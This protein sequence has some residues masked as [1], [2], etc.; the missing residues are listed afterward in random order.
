MRLKNCGVKEFIS[1]VEGKRLI[2]FGAG[3]LILDMAFEVKT[4]PGLEQAIDCFVD[5]DSE[6]WGNC[7]QLGVRDFTI[8]SPDLLLEQGAGELV[9]LITCMAYQSVIEQLQKIPQL[10]ACD[11]YLY[12][13]VLGIPNLDVAHFFGEEIYRKP[14]ADY[15]ERLQGLQLKDKYKKRRCFIIGNGPSLTPEDLTLLRDEI[16]FASNR[17]FFIFSQTPWRPTYYFCI[18]Y[19]ICAMDTEKMQ[20]VACEN[21]FMP[22]ACALATGRVYDDWMYFNRQIIHYTKTADGKVT[23]DLSFDFSKDITQNTYAGQTVTYDMM[24]FAYYMGF[25]EVYLLGMDHSSAREVR[26][27]GTLVTNNTAA[28]HFSKEYDAELKENVAVVA[29]LYASAVAYQAAKTAFEEDGRR[30]YN[31]TRGGSLE[32]F[33]RKS[34]E[35]IFSEKGRKHHEV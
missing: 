30:I 25:D 23:R 32:I 17:I 8:H 7:I 27:D 26:E 18:D 22:L 2:C 34:L 1:R 31:A 24:Q 20:S 28:D 33:Q 15:R 3:S 12:N 11:C 29:P 4:I 16:T 19:L 10:V 5:N 21:K 35:E 14:Y 13:C 6:K 9:I